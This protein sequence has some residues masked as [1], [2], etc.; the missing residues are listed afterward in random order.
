MNLRQIQALFTMG[1]ALLRHLL[2][3]PLA[4]RRGAAPWL[5]RLRR[6]S[7]APTAPQSW[8]RFAP[9][10]RCIGCGLCDTLG[11]GSVAPSAMILAV[12][13]RPEDAPLVIGDARAL[14]LLAADIARICPARVGVQDIAGLIV[15]NAAM[16]SSR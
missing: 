10:G 5:Q 11:E 7:L 16:L 15:D 3:M 13:R 2:L 6:E 8:Q 9:A 12:G 14:V 4:R 1:M